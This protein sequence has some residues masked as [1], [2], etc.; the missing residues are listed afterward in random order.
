MK[1]SQLF[2][3]T[4]KNPREYDSANAT[5]LIKAGF[6]DQVMSGVYTFLPL[7]NRVLQKIENIVREEMNKIGVELLMP[8][9]TPKEYWKETGR[10]EDI[11]I[12]FKALGAN[13]DSRR[14]NDS[15]YIL[16]PTHEEVVT[17]LAKKFRRSYK[18]F[19]FA[20]YQLQTKFRNEA[21][22]KSGLLRAREF[23]MKDLYSFHTS[24]ED[25]QE[26]YEKAKEAYWNVFERLGIKEDTVIAAAS[27][28]TFTSDFS[29]EFQTKCETGEDLIFQV[30]STGEAFNREVAPSKA[31]EIQQDKELKDL[32]YK[33]EAGIIG[34]E[35]LCKAFG[36]SADQS[37][38]TLLFETNS[39]DQPIVIAALRGDYD[40]NEYKLMK[41]I[42]CSK[43][44][45]ASEEKVKEI[46]GAEIGYAGI[47]DL[48]KE[49]PVYFDDSI[50]GLVN[51]ECGAN[52]TNYHVL[53]VNWGRDVEKPEKF[54][55]I[56]LAKEGDLFSETME[57]YETFQASEVGNIFPLHTKFSDSLNY[58]Y[59]NED[60]EERPILMGCYGLGTSRVLGVL[61]E[62]LHDENG[63][64][65][66]VTVA[67]FHTHLIHIG[68]SNFEKSEYIYDQLQNNGIEVL[69]DE[70]DDVSVGEKFADADLIGCPFRVVVSDKTL[71]Q[72]SV[73]IK[74]RDSDKTQLVPIVE[75]SEYIED[76]L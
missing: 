47:I 32:E 30:P 58:T 13:E 64:I 69:W 11:D 56:K 4:D 65:W 68:E 46:T 28:G 71:E 27:G 42:G 36:I 41:I 8:A 29:H 24:V 66:P 14:L 63:I 52:R 49:V 75:L 50:E 3:K 76:N 2:S 9:M 61:V 62:K 44:R 72:D 70:R 21:R 38:K 19:P 17:P 57:E 7:G 5:L 6:I 60:G 1:Y 23:R 73:E 74:R 12:L 26:Y 48:P 20:V 34:V 22:P 33:E 54:Y 37:V 59:V 10:L 67:P 39:E 16:C 25:L 15:E 45:L 43:M 35:Q 31:P 40:I 18:D 53:N 51:F 55:D